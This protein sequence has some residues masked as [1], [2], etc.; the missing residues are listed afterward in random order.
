M[1]VG[2]HVSFVSGLNCCGGDHRKVVD[3]RYFFVRN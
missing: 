1:H 2:S 3:I